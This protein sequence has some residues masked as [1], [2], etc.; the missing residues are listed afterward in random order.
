MN[1]ELLKQAAKAEGIV[2]TSVDV[3]ARLVQIAEGVGGDE[4]L[5]AKMVEFGITEAT[6]RRD[7]ESEIL[8]QGLFDVKMNVNDIEVA[9]A[10]IT[11]LYTDL[12]GE[13]GGLPPLTEV[14]EQITQQIKQN[15]QQELVTSY[16]EELRAKATIEILV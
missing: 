8:I 2:V 11:K 4:A 14:R 15:K 6:L 16:I 7:I 10:E 3:E 9:E 1:G 13:G 5:K 12:G